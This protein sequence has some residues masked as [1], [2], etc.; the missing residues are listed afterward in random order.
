MARR[1]TYNF[2]PLSRPAKEPE[3]I[4]TSANRPP[5]RQNMRAITLWVPEE[6]KEIL[7]ILMF[8][9]RRTEQ[10]LM[11]EALNDFFAKHG[12]HRVAG[13]KADTAT[14]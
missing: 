6:A 5:S 9:T 10:A 12:K 13:A 4:P 14:R 1:P 3:P 8:E 2:S 11:A 7:R